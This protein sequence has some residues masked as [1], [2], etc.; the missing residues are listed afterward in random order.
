MREAHR[1]RHQAI[2]LANTC[3]IALEELEKTCLRSG[4]ALYAAEGHRGNAMVHV[5]EIQHEILHPERRAFAD[6]GRLGWLQMRV[7]K[8]GLRAPLARER[9]EHAQNAENAAAQ[10]LQAAAHHDEIRVV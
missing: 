2:E 7:A 8:R 6:R 4:R 3:V 5:G 9:A 10:E 1:G